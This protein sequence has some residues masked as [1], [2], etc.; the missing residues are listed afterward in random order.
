MLIKLRHTDSFGLA[1]GIYAAIS[2]VVLLREALGLSGGNELTLGLSFAAWLVGVGVGAMVAGRLTRP[3]AALAIASFAAPFFVGG[4]LAAL[5]LF[6]DVLG[7]APGL[8]PSLL[9]LA[10]LLAAGVGAGGLTVGFLFTAGARGSEEKRGAPVSRLYTA[11]AAGALIGGLVFAFLLAGRVSHSVAIGLA[12]SLPAGAIAVAERGRVRGWVLGV[13][14]LALIGASAFGPLAALDL[15]AEIRAFETMGAGKELVDTKDSAYGRLTLGRSDEEFVLLADGRL[16]HTFPDPWERP[17]PVHLALTQHP[18]PKRVLILGGG[19]SDRLEAALLHRPERVVFTYLDEGAHDLCRPFWSAATLAALGDPRVEIVR[20]D[21]RRFVSNTESRFDV[22]IIFTRPPLSG[23][24]N[25][26]HTREFFA[27]LHRILAP[28]GSVTVFAPG[29]A[30]LLAPEAARA[31]ASE[32]AALRSVFADVV[33][34]PGARLLLHAASKMGVVT[35]DPIILRD[36]YDRRGVK[37]K[38]FSSRRFESLFAPERVGAI[39]SQIAQWPSA[40]NTDLK[41]VVYLAALQLWERSLSEDR[42]A[43]SPTWIG[44]AEQWAWL[45]IVLPLAVWILWQVIALARGRAGSG[46]VVFSIATTGACGMAVEIVVL[47]VFQ[48]ASGQ[49]YTGLAVLVALFMA[50]LAGGAHWGRRDLAAG[51]L[52][53]SLFVEIVMLVVVVASGWVMRASIDCAPVVALWGVV[54]GIVTGASFPALL[55]RAA[56]KNR[57]DERQAAASIEVADH[58]GAAW[59]A[60]VTGV[61]WLPVFGIMTTCLLLACF[62]IISLMTML[63][64]GTS[65]VRA[66]QASV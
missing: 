10:C 50:G 19:P 40:I 62:K 29:G 44:V 14:S 21:G 57:G 54:V 56:L 45:W 2:Q 46:A 53:G 18:A 22:V 7:V 9:G 61:I 51:R 17:I 38:S 8:D 13:F 23:Q 1:L 6:R 58:L 47:Y 3:G 39:R 4:G 43:N 31:A 16:D 41:P 24:V 65:R 64:A 28:G 42:S 66:R 36:R 27:S 20:D 37:A 35:D 48:A 49:L 59:G 33:V 5:R 25:R 55:G 34:V 63:L 52:R 11:E 12:G 32:L 26:Y 30:N 60:L 15:V